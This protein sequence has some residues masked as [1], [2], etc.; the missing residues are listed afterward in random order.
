MKVPELVKDAKR[1]LAAEC[2]IVIGLQSTGEASLGGATL[3]DGRFPS[4][5]KEII[6]NFV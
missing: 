2:A 6:R 3:K 1:H 5:C 4:T